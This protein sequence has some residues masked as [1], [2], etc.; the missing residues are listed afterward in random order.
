MSVTSSIFFDLIMLLAYTA[1]MP[2]SDL[3]CFYCYALTS[4]SNHNSQIANDVT[5]HYKSLG[6][7]QA[8]SFVFIIQA[9]SMF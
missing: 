2:R 9:K 3:I 1:C 6:C 5:N 4:A 8:L 7:I